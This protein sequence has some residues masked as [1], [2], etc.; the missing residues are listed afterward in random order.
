MSFVLE[1]VGQLQL[2]S[3]FC[4]FIVSHSGSDSISTLARLLNIIATFR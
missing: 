4:L 2:F 3:Q 1:H